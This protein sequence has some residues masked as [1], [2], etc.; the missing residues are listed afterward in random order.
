MSSAICFNSDQSKILLYGNGYGKKLCQI[1]LKS[2]HKYGSYGPDKL[3]R[4]DFWTDTYT[5][6]H[7]PE[8][9]CDDYV[10]IITKGPRQI[11]LYGSII[12]R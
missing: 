4:T 3:G 5:N 1:L 6:A 2:I 10:S 7:T 9:H 12:M 8:C 11:Y